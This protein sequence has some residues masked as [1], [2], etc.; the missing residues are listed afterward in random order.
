MKLFSL[1][2]LPLL[3][4]A[5]DDSIRGIRFE[6]NLSWEQVKEKAKSEN[7][8]IFLDVYATWCGPCRVMDRD[9]YSNDSVGNMMNSK[10]ISV[11]V[12]VDSTK[13]DNEYVKKWYADAS[14]ISKA[15]EI[16]GYPCFLF[17]SP[18]AKLVYKEIGYKN[19]PDFIKLMKNALVS[20]NSLYYSQLE[21][22]KKG[23]KSY[24]GMGYLAVFVKKIIGD[25]ALSN[26]IAR[27]YKE[28]FLDILNEEALYTKESLEFIKMFPNLINSRDHFFHLCYTQPEKIDQIMRNKGWA[29]SQVEQIVIREEME[30]KLLKNKQP[31]FANP[32]W[33]QIRSVINKKY[34]KI[35]AQ[36][37]LLDYQI[38]YYRFY[39]LN[40][41][42]WA[43]YKNKK[44]KSYPPK[45]AGLEIYSELNVYGAWD[46]FLNCNDKRILTKALKWIDIALQADEEN[47]ATYLDT[48]ANLLYKLGKVE[49]AI[50]MEQKA[51]K[52]DSIH[53]FNIIVI[54]M[55]NGEPTYLE[56]GA[57]WNACTLTKKGNRRKN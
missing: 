45:T 53:S 7:K 6:Q 20:E 55:K 23:I 37:L 9:I 14:Q 52:I 16:P 11:K 19:V 13:K 38:R 27:D 1:L 36:H 40:W 54:K 2:Y 5:Q 35:D 48:K 31:I 39:D 44:I 46:A 15:Y 41:R 24:K 47:K 21:D 57:I 18:D 51:T 17:F 30:N 12:Q 50:I 4:N 49:Q 43:V 34:K 32:D 8:Y 29:N 28:K 3:L 56:E 42:L 26:N 33:N 22:Y 10:L 25:K